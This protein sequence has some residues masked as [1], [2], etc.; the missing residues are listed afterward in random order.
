MMG[1]EERVLKQQVMGMKK[2][3]ADLEEAE[4]RERVRDSSI[5]LFL[6]SALL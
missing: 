4:A 2:Q 1:E 5:F 3:C 6:F